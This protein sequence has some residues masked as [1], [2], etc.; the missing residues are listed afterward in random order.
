VAQNSGKIFEDDFRKSIPHNIY[1]YRLRDPASSFGGGSENLRFSIQ[2][3]YDC[4][5][6]KEPNFFPVELKSTKGTSF[7][8]QRDKKEKNKM[9]K[10]NQIKGLTK[11][12]QHSGVLAGFIFNF[13]SNNN[14]TYWLNIKNFNEFNSKT[15]KKSINENDVKEFGGIQIKN[16]LK[17]VRYRYFIDEFIEKLQKGVNEVAI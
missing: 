11:A 2:N 15:E 13:R 16:E 14:N 6:Y 5:L 3:D 4:F 12:S 8:I 9:I 10:L 17:R 7:S 1:F